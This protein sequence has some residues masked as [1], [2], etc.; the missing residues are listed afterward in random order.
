MKAL[1]AGNPH[2]RKRGYKPKIYEVR[3][4]LPCK[5]CGIPFKIMT[6]ETT[7]YFEILSKC[8]ELHWLPLNLE[9]FE[10]LDLKMSPP[11]TWVRYDVGYA[12][13]SDLRAGDYIDKIKFTFT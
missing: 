1:K 12:T 7:G 8:E 2:C 13:M 10:R 11:A 3:E 6:E 4:I 5:V 9:K